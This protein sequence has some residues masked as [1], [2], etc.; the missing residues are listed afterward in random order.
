MGRSAVPAP[1]WLS[2]ASTGYHNAATSGPAHVA[3]IASSIEERLVAQPV[4]MVKPPTRGRLLNSAISTL[5]LRN[6]EDRSHSAVSGLQ[7]DLSHSAVYL[8]LRDDD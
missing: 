6:D 5:N 7:R 8:D 2:G 4:V 3:H 1:A